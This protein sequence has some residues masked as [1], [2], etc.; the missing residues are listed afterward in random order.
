M[1]YPDLYS[2]FQIIVTVLSLISEDS[3]RAIL[4]STYFS[5]NLFFR[6]PPS[7]IREVPTE[8]T[9]KYAQPNTY[10][11]QHYWIKVYQ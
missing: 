11:N 7:E 10:I 2:L 5:W 4:Q 8:I 6:S 3:R 9:Q 1:K